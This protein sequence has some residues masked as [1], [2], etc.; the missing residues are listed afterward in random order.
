MVVFL[1]KFFVPIFLQSNKKRIILSSFLKKDLP[2][3]TL[4]FTHYCT[5]YSKHF[6]SLFQE[7]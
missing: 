2:K 5:L 1:D 4:V 7:Y 3:I 6:F